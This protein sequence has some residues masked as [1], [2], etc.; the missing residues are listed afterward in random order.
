M[1]ITIDLTARHED[2]GDLVGDV[3]RELQDV[4]ERLESLHLELADVVRERMEVETEMAARELEIRAEQIR[5]AEANGAPKDP[6]TGRANKDY[7]EHLLAVALRED[8]EYQALKGRKEELDI[9][10]QELR[11]WIQGATAQLRAYEALSGLLASLCQHAK[12][13]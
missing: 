1:T 12:I 2:L 7:V 10:V 5:Q 8:P 11:T 6:R 13:V 3:M 9:R 4:A